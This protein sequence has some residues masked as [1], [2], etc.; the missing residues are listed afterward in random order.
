[1]IELDRFEDPR[2]LLVSAEKG[3][4]LPFDP[5]RFF[6]I[7]DVPAGM[8]RSDHANITGSELLVALQGYCTVDVSLGSQLS[9]YVLDT[10]DRALHAPGMHWLRCREFSDD[11]VLLVLCDQPYDAADQVHDWAS[12][13]ALV[14]TTT[15]A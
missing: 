3:N 7:R 12:Y 8:H 6:V 2:G 10:P 1:M 13:L 9:T 15:H 11:C 5:V 14:A 4:G